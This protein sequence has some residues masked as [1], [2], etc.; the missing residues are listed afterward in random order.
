MNIVEAAV[1]RKIKRKESSLGLSR[2]LSL[3]PGRRESLWSSKYD[4]EGFERIDYK[5]PKG[6]DEE[7]ILK[8][9]HLVIVA[10]DLEKMRWDSN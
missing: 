10:E 3:H 2:R 7:L 5:I 8:R 4:E 6:R 9:K 1:E